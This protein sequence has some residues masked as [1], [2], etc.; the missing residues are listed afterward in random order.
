[1]DNLK[2]TNILIVGGAGFIGSNL[3][4][5]LLTRDIKRIVIIDNLLSSEKENI[6][7]DSRVHFIKGSINDNRILK[8]VTDEFDFVFQLATYHGNQNSILNPLADHNNNTLVTLKLFERIKNFKKIKKVVYSSAGCSVAKKTYGI[9]TATTE[10]SPIEINQDSPYSISKIIGEFYSA[11]YFKQNYLPIV[12]ARFQNVYGPG[13][14]LGAGKWRGTP[15]TVWRNV[16]PA[17][18]HK[19]IKGEPLPLDGDGKSSRDF[20][21]VEDICLGLI[22]CA[23]N[24]KP[25]DVYNLASGSETS[26]IDLALLINNITNNSSAIKY[27]PKRAWDSSGRRFGSTTKS[28]KDLDFK[29]TT[30]LEEGLVQTINWTKDNLVFIDSL[31]YKHKKKMNSYLSSIV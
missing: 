23:I 17:F 7:E 4:N 20:I 9:A 8:F 28:Q 11:Y 18:I 25:G 29:T 12:R 31:I 5:L 22:K 30:K 2:N 21:F 3:A 19:A 26:I 24:G 10:D 15:A 14:L 16:V 13:E 27:L 1:M 6:P